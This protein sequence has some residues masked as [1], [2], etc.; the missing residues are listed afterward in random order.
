MCDV[1]EELVRRAPRHLRRVESNLQLEKG[2][3]DSLDQ[4]HQ[5]LVAPQTVDLEIYGGRNLE[6]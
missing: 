2:W 4:K 6:K 5:L 1:A 3:A